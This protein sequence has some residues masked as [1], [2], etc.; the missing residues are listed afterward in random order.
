M[1]PPLRRTLCLLSLC[2][3]AMACEDREILFVEDKAENSG[4]ST[5]EVVGRGTD[6]A[7]GFDNESGPESACAACLRTKCAPQVS[8]CGDVSVTGKGACAQALSCLADAYDPSAPNYDCA[9]VSCNAQSVGNQAVDQMFTCTSKT[10]APSCFVTE[11][12]AS[13]SE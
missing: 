2:G 7:S 5:S 1:A 12:F 10:C 3:V 6:F 8:A 11:D 13:C 4:G 9:F